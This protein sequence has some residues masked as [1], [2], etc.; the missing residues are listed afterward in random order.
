M[1]SVIMMSLDV[2]HIHEL[3]N[4]EQTDFTGNG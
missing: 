4:K 1:L 2:N 3:G